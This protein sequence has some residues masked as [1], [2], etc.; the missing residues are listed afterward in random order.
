M[1]ISKKSQGA[2][3]FV[4]VFFFIFFLISVA[5]SFVGYYSVEVLDEQNQKDLEDFVKSVDLESQLLQKSSPGFSRTVEIPEHIMKRF[6]FSINGSYLI[7]N[8]IEYTINETYYYSLSGNVTL[9]IEE[10]NGTHYFVMQKPFTKTISGI[11][12]IN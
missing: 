4:L 11:T 9:Q 1:F 12:L 7:I 5:M 3:E 2:L 10:I 8:S 6:D